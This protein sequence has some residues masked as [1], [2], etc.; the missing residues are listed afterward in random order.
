MKGFSASADKVVKSLAVVPGRNQLVIGGSFDKLSSTKRESIGS[1][2]LTTGAVQSWEPSFP[3]PVIS[4][5]AD[6][7]DIYVAGGGE[8]ATS[9]TLTPT[10]RRSTGAAAPTATPR[11]S[12]YLN[13]VVYVG[14]HFTNYCGP[15]VGAEVCTQPTRATSSWPSMH[16]PAISSR[17]ASRRTQRSVS[18][19]S[20]EAEAS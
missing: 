2:D 3:Y 15:I 12:P 9:S 20:P 10:R 11:R 4:V 18:S 5:A 19:R 8:A 7:D 6:T 14:G 13:G 1:L 17:G 16:S